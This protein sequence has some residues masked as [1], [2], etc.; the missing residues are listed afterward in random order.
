MFFILIV[1]GALWLVS[2]DRD[3]FVVSVE[4][5]GLM[6]RIYYRTSF[7]GEVKSV[8]FIGFVDTKKI[9][10]CISLENITNY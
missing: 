3:G 7:G 1:V 2:E 5:S 6:G 10:E 4:S 8:G 9:M